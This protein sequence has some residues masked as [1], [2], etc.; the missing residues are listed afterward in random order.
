M[1]TDKK[2]LLIDLTCSDSETIG[3]MWSTS[4]SSNMSAVFT[5]RTVAKLT[6]HKLWFYYKLYNNMTKY[7]G[8]C[9]LWEYR[10]SGQQAMET[11]K[12]NKQRWFVGSPSEPWPCDIFCCF[13][14]SLS[15]WSSIALGWIDNNCLTILLL[16]LSLAALLW[17]HTTI[18]G[19]IHKIY[20]SFLLALCICKLETIT[21]ESSPA[22][23]QQ[24]SFNSI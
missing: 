17:R 18:L 23:E 6:K 16:W 19:S 22:E 24:T 9:E 5:F 12:A 7:F 4:T 20:S 1:E 21:F 10:L 8:L 14:S 13:S 2:L 11:K 15:L 3:N